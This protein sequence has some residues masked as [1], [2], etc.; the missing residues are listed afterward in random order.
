V[1]ASG[2]PILTLACI[3]R[4]KVECMRDLRPSKIEFL[5]LM[6]DDMDD[7][8]AMIIGALKASSGDRALE[9]ARSQL[10][11]ARDEKRLAWEAYPMT[12]EMGYARGRAHPSRGAR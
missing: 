6:T 8:D 12:A 3:S 9:A 5:L 4:D 10:Q 7:A 2:H 1:D 11:L